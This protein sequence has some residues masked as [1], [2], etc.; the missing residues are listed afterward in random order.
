M[1]GGLIGAYASNPWGEGLGDVGKMLMYAGVKEDDE[2]ARLDYYRARDAAA[3]DQR[4]RVLEARKDA[5]VARAEA[6][7]AGGSRG[8]A[9]DGIPIKDLERGGAAR[10][11]I[12]ERAGL[13][14]DQMSAVEDYMRGNGDRLKQENEYGK[15]ESVAEGD[16]AIKS[17]N[18]PIEPYTK[19]EYPPGFEAEAK[20]KARMIGEIRQSLVLGKEAKNVAEGEQVTFNTDTAR[21][22]LAGRIPQS[23]GAAAVGVEKGTGAWK[24]GGGTMYNQYTSE[25]DPTDVGRSTIRKNDDMGDAAQTRANRPPAEKKAD[26]DKPITGIDLERQAKAAK[27]ALAD[28]LGVAPG[29]VEEELAKLK[30]RNKLTPEI[31][32]LHTQYTSALGR[33]KSYKAQP[34]AEPT[35]APTSVPKAPGKRDYSNLWR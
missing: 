35:S 32:E 27:A 25:N 15:R 28:E 5:E 33:W 26:G 19:R 8:S 9:T 30:R 34:G 24:E 12:L 6:R 22:V 3:I 14:E 10:G 20:D 7:A 16:D 29:K 18:T 4:D 1:S 17:K 13:T 21:G 31:E 2:K 11:L 23:E